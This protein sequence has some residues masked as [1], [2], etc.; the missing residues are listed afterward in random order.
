[1]DITALLRIDSYL[2]GKILLQFNTGQI[3]HIQKNER[4]GAVRDSC[5]IRA[6]STDRIFPLHLHTR[7][8]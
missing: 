8:P 4:I 6:Q 7:K 5:A 3:Y 2:S 1:M